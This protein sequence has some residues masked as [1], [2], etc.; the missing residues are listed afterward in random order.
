MVCGYGSIGKRQRNNSVD[1]MLLAVCWNV[2]FAEQVYH[3]EGGIAVQSIKRLF[4]NA[5]NQQNMEK[6]FVRIVKEYR[7]KL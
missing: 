2:D 5:Y 3:D 6:D 7:N 1:N 4:G